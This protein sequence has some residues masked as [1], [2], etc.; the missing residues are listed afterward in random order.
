MRRLLA[1][2]AGIVMLVG[3]SLAWAQDGLEAAKAAGLVGERADGLAGIVS[4][5]APADVR[6]LVERVNAARL[7]RYREIARTNGVAPDQV[8]A[9]AGRKLVD[10]TP[11]G[12]FVLVPGRGWTRK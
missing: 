2:F 10:E 9:L 5:R 12:Q 6:A 7:A 1:A 8:Q 11:K 4:D 3:A